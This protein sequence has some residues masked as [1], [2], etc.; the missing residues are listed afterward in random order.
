[1]V[2]FYRDMWPKR[3]ELLV[4]LSTMTSSKEKFKWTPEHD[5]AF[6]EMKKNMARETI[7]SFSYFN[8]PFEIH[9]DASKV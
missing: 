8:K 5:K 6:Q 1:M 3:S 9:T 2:H 4:P 7:L